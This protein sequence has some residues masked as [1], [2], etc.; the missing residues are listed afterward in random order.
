VSAH[1]SRVEERADA[2]ADNLLQSIAD[3]ELL[4]SEPR[5]PRHDVY[6]D[7]GAASAH[8]SS[9]EGRTGCEFGT[10]DAVVDEDE[11]L[12]RCLLLALGVLARVFD[13]S[14][15]GFLLVG[16]AVLLGAFVSINRSGWR[17]WLSYQFSGRKARWDSRRALAS[18]TSSA[19]RLKAM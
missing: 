11:V 5:F 2:G 14:C 15:D 18:S 1:G 7:A 8:S 10:A 17:V 12:V 16:H 19:S 4:A 13:L 3:L 6:L 9:A